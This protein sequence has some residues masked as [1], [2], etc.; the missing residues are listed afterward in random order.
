[1]SA[2]Q[3]NEAGWGKL[4]LNPAVC[5]Q[6]SWVAAQKKIPNRLT[7]AVW[8]YEELNNHNTALVPVLLFSNIEKKTGRGKL[9][10]KASPVHQK[11][12]KQKT[13]AALKAVRV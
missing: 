9:V 4:V 1:L 3:L 2:Q 5:G 13:R 6:K 7:S 11:P 10:I 12:V 8:D